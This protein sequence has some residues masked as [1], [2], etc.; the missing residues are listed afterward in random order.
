MDTK[1]AICGLYTRVSS[2]NQLEVEYNSLDTQRERLEAYC[3][4]QENHEIYRV[5]EDGA[6]SGDSV[7]RPALKEMLQDIRDGKVNRVLVYKIDRLTR[8]VKDFHTLMDVFDRYGTTFVS[9]TQSIDTSSPTGRLLRNVIVDFAQFEREMIADR[10]RDKM[11]QRAQKGLWHGGVSPYGYRLK[12]KY[13]VKHSQEAACVHFMFEW[14]AETPSLAKLR[15]E[16]HRRGWYTR[17]GNPW[18]KTALDCIL[19]NPLHYGMVHYKEQLYKGQHEP[20]IDEALFQKAQ[21]LRRDY[22]HVSSRIDRVFLLRGLLKCSDCGSFMTP[23]YTQKR[24]KDGSVY[25]IPYYRC[26]KT[27]H[28]NN[29]VCR[30]K[31][32]NADQVERLI[33]QDLHDLSQN[34][35]YL[36][37]SIEELNRDL[38]RRI[39]PLAKDAERIKKRLGEVEA[40]IGRFVKALG[41]G[42]LSVNRLEKEIEAREKDRKALQVLYDDLQQKIREDVVREY[43]AELVKRTLQSFQETFQGLSPKEQ[44]EALQCVLKDVIAYPDKFALDIYELAE[45]TPGSQNNPRWLPREDSNLGHA[46]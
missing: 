25:R 6:Q 11:H 35:A 30:I 43:N 34:E 39:E 21:S 42:K 1:Q 22:S 5:Y 38:Q 27:M 33:I 14:F 7:D 17:A 24:H 20:I 46:R 18:G 41:Q 37:M 29:R 3:R 9:T 10:T 12:D 19:R 4:S 8:S 32:L 26:T 44:A 31:H 28:Y 40:E 36:G 13:L 23:H 15:E 45:F 16:L 2:R